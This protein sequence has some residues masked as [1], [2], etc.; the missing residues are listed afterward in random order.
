MKLAIL[1]TAVLLILVAGPIEQPIAGLGPLES[2]AKGFMVGLWKSLKGMKHREATRRRTFSGSAS[3]DLSFGG[4]IAPLGTPSQNGWTGSRVNLTG[5]LDVRGKKYPITHPDGRRAMRKLYDGT[6]TFDA[7][8]TKLSPPTTTVPPVVNIVPAIPEVVTVAPESE[9]IIKP[10]SEEILFIEPVPEPEPIVPLTEAILPPAEE[11]PAVVAQPKDTPDFIVG[12][13][14]T[15]AIS[16]DSK[17]ET[18]ILTESDSIPEFEKGVIVKIIQSNDD[19]AHLKGVF[20]LNV[21]NVGSGTGAIIHVHHKS[22][23]SSSYATPSTVLVPPVDDTF[24]NLAI[25]VDTGS[26]STAVTDGTGVDSESITGVDGTFGGSSVLIQDYDAGNPNEGSAPTSFTDDLGAP[27]DINDSTGFDSFFNGE[28][29]N[30]YSNT[31]GDESTTGVDYVSTVD[32]P[33]TAFDDYGAGETLQT[34]DYPDAGNPTLTVSDVSDTSTASEAVV[35]DSY[36]STSAVT[37]P[38]IIIAPDTLYSTPDDTQA[39]GEYVVETLTHAEGTTGDEVDSTVSVS[40][41][42]ANL[43]DHY[44]Q[45]NVDSVRELSNIALRH[46]NGLPLTIRLR[47]RHRVSTPAHSKPVAAQKIAVGSLYNGQVMMPNG[48][49]YAVKKAP[50]LHKYSDVIESPDASQPESVSD[51]SAN[52]QYNAHVTMSHGNLHAVKKAPLLHKYSDVIESP[53][54]SQPESVSDHS[55]NNE[56]NVV[57]TMP[58]GQLY[59]VKKAPLL[60]KY[61]DVIESPD[62]S[63]VE[64]VSDHSINAVDGAEENVGGS[65]SVAKSILNAHADTNTIKENIKIIR[66]EQPQPVFNLIPIQ[67]IP[68][69]TEPVK[70]ITPPSTSRSQDSSLQFLARFA[71]AHRLSSMFRNTQG[72]NSGSTKREEANHRPSPSFNKGRTMNRHSTFEGE[73]Y[74]DRL[75]EVLSESGVE[76]RSLTH[77]RQTNPGI[78]EASQPRPSAGTSHGKSASSVADPFADSSL[79]RKEKSGVTRAKLLY[80]ERQ[81]VPSP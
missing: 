20:N 67:I 78:I 52:N 65:T 81:V 43:Y 61:S 50:L 76:Q 16:V 8:F 25:E 15:P 44:V 53:D 37:G 62:A 5:N 64:S 40:G 74:R 46:G 11:T 13:K 70:Q 48:K 55:V 30:D 38:E 58:R 18:I 41:A 28:T 36:D 63:R 34:S 51:H 3:A 69:V 35:V 59:A 49:L 27:S 54:A 17:P 1:P 26:A 39:G 77:F 47:T 29:P 45:A 9:L 73:E 24:E 33:V 23:G 72:A 79:N 31:V 10:E 22:S 7:N 80:R 60:H 71:E 75:H 12:V 56:Y 68:P 32:A 21:A 66:K 14:E 6:V 2:F 57:V 42:P 4:H 19:S